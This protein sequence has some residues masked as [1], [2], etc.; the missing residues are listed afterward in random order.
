MKNQ[1]GFMPRPHEKKVLVS[2]ASFWVAFFIPWV[3]GVIFILKTIIT[4][5]A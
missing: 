4:A 2:G 3:V 1:P 5:L